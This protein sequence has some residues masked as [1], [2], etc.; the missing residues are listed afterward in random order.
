[1]MALESRDYSCKFKQEK[2]ER[3]AQKNWDK[4]FNRNG[5]KFFRD[6]HWTIYELE[7]L[8]PQFNLKDNQLLFLEAGCGVG[9]LAFPLMTELPNSKWLMCDFSPKAIDLVKQNELFSNDRC[10]AFVT[11]LTK[12]LLSDAVAS[13][14]VDI[15]TLVFVLSSISPEKMPTVLTNIRGILKPGGSIVFRDYGIGDHAMERFANG[16]KLD[17]NFYVRQDGT[18]AFYFSIDYVKRLFA[19][20]G[21]SCIKCD[22]VHKETINRKENLRVPRVFLQGRFQKPFE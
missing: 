7:E 4:F 2:L 21:F 1:M 17:E 13:E 10:N 15:C 5:T 22:Y 18:R 20:C 6:R 3:E 8:F 9:N 16:S 12:T 19:D 14:S 11:D